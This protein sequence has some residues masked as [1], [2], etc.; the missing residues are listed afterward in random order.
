MKIKVVPDPIQTVPGDAAVLV[1]F[2]GESGGPAGKFL[3]ELAASREFT[4]KLF[5]TVWV[6]RP[7]GFAARRLL[8]VGGGKPEKFSLRLLR[9]AAGAAAR[10]LKGKG[11]REAAMAL[12]ESLGGAAAVS[13]VVEGAILG[14]WEPDRHKSEKEDS[15][16]LE[17]FAVAGVEAGGDLET[18]AAHGRALAEAQNFTRELVNEPANRLPPLELARQARELASRCALDCEVLDQDRM[19]QMGMGALL[20]VA[21]GSAEPPALIVLRYRPERAASADHLGLIGKGVTFDSGGLSIKP[22]DGMEKMKYDMAGGAA[23]LG[24][25]QAIAQWKPPVAVTALVPAVENMTGSRAQRPG[26]IVTTLSGKTVEVL[27]TD[28][29]GRLILADALTYAR[30]LGCTHLVD[31]AT[32]TGAVVVALGHVRAG[33]FSNHD[34]F[35]ARVLAAADAEGER[36][37]ALPMDEDYKEYL[38]SACADIA[39]VGGRWA[40]AITAAVFLKEFVQ[41][42]P[43]VH[44]D[45]A[46]T[47][48]QEEAKPYAAKGPTGVGVRTFVR[49]AADWV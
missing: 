48:W 9:Q 17:A 47:A 29:E 41:D 16:A 30:Q 36:M 31:A 35:Q 39:N 2:E 44:L 43:W 13:A 7:E 27:N 3:A 20:G 34:A 45:I 14:H 40:G 21:Q 37:W 49:L 42:T 25:M 23:V 8:L 33:V 26:D 38:K 15:T 46:G 12:P 22:A 19:R 4:G 32:L 5:D 1:A 10:V 28:A 18:A 6:H 24:A 11:C